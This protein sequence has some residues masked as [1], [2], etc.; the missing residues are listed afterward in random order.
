MD[1]LVS[2]SAILSPHS[3]YYAGADEAKTRGSDAEGAV[4]SLHVSHL[5]YK[6][7]DDRLW[8][9]IPSRSRM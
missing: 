9:S 4:A 2:D 5:I 3:G 7:G 6:Y 1:S 8:F